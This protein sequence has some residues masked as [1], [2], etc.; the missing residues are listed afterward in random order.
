MEKSV[1]WCEKLRCG[2]EWDFTLNESPVC[3]HCGHE[4]EP[5]DLY[6]IFEEGEHYINCSDCGFDYWV[7]TSVSWKF[8]T[9]RQGD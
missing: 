9:H 4:A 3:P 8:S 5:S 6:Y 7:S 2:D 1:E